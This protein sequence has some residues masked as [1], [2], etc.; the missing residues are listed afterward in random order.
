MDY[1]KNFI[2]RCLLLII[3]V[4]VLIGV[5]G[6]LVALIGT[7]AVGILSIVGLLGILGYDAYKDTRKERLLKE[8]DKNYNITIEKKPQAT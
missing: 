8:I 3:V 6:G 5:G 7:K 2:A 1:I 4:A